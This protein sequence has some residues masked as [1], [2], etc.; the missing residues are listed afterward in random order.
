MSTQQL[1]CIGAVTGAFGVR[2]D[3]RVKSFCAD[4]AAIASYGPVFTEDGAR[5]FEIR[6]VKAL[7]GAF[8]VRLSGVS[9]RE[10]ADALRGT[11]LH[12]PRDVLPDPGDDEYYHSDL[13]GLAA[14][15]PG[16]AVLGRVVAVHDH[17]AGDYLEIRGAGDSRLVP[18]TQA[19]VPTVDI[20][21]GRIIVDHHDGDD[22]AP[23][24]DPET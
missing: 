6:I 7:S 11:R 14:L 21:G 19:A 17:G 15:D 23:P 4:P 22:E 8:A 20:A 5:Q 10:Q 16:G 24:E 12:V 2:G 3:V 18:F 1:I 13:V 9:T